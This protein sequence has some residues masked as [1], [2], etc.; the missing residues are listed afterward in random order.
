MCLGGDAEVVQRPFGDVA[1]LLHHGRVMGC[2]IL[3]GRHLQT[4][5]DCL[6]D[7]ADQIT[8]QVVEIV[9]VGLIKALLNVIVYK[10]IS[11]ISIIR[12][13]GGTTN[14][15]RVTSTLRSY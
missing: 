5:P 10:S 4:R 9:E 7:V 1:R 2:S 14:G 13:V 6:L 15:D 11:I 8:V 12:P 3:F